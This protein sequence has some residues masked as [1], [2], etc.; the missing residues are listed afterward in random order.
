MARGKGGAR[1]HNTTMIAGKRSLTIPPWA[2]TL[3]QPQSEPSAMD[4]KE[5]LV[6]LHSI[7]GYQG[8]RPRAEEDSKWEIALTAER[9]AFNKTLNRST[10]SPSILTN[11]ASTS[12]HSQP[13]L[14][15]RLLSSIPGYTGVRHNVRRDRQ[16]QHLYSTEESDEINNVYKELSMAMHTDYLP[17]FNGQSA[18]RP[19]TQST[20][21]KKSPR[22]PRSHEHFHKSCSETDFAEH[23]RRHAHAN[24]FAKVRGLQVE[25][26]RH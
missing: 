20:F 9:R 19:T 12:L 1:P 21:T 5:K 8:F 7:P 17:D 3:D 10:K 26:Q 18:Y 15:V 11:T 24:P 13:Q 14:S 4:K 22:S 23:Y 6:T 16:M 25:E 2:T